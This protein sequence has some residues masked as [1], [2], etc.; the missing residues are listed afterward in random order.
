MLG[1]PRQSWPLGHKALSVVSQEQPLAWGRAS[2]ASPSQEASHQK[3]EP[4]TR[5]SGNTTAWASR[6]LQNTRTEPNLHFTPTLRVTQ[7][8]LSS[9]PYGITTAVLLVFNLLCVL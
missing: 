6:V 1:G 7:R 4:W 8:E 5:C 3:A 2:G 9:S